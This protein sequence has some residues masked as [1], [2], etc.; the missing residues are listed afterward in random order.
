MIIIGESLNGFIKA[1]ANAIENRDEAYLQSLA[2]RQ[3]A[4]GA[5]YLDLCA[6]S[7]GTDEQQT[8]RW[9]VSIAERA[10]SIPLCLDSPN[11]ET[12]AAVLPYCKRAGIVN[13]VSMES[14]KIET[15]FPLLASTDWKFIALLCSNA[16]VP[17]SVSGRLEL[18][19]QIRAA[20]KQYGIAENRLMIE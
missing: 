15:L 9:L 12:I 14:G 2:L 16:G 18:F 8:L 19:E 7:S 20:A 13:S 6:A 3:E 10:V 5:D 11:P 1:T 17:E 4:A